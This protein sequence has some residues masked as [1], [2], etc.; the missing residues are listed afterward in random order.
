MIAR[1]LEEN[2]IPTVTLNM[3]K[4]LGE[5]NQPPRIIFTDHDFGAPFGKPHDDEEQFSLV[6][7]CL[8]KFQD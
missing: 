2:G 8:T 6:R 5:Y 7:K 3:F 4:E 1:Y